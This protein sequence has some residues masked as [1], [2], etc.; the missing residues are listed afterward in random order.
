MEIETDREFVAFCNI[1]ETFLE[2]IDTIK[3]DASSALKARNFIG[4]FVS[5][6]FFS[7]RNATF[8]FQE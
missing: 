2:E 3:E 5:P 8:Q 4:S 7:Q 1:L 6:T